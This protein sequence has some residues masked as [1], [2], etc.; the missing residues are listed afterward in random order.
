MIFICVGRSE[1]CRDTIAPDLA[2]STPEPLYD[3]DQ[4]LQQR[5]DAIHRNLWIGIPECLQQGCEQHAQVLA[6]RR[7]RR[8]RQLACSQ[9]R[10][11]ASKS[12]TAGE[13][14]KAKLF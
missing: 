13:L 7:Q 12:A 11:P 4:G 10:A 14:T 1:Q 8:S 2:N 9:R 5:I 3:G 6:F